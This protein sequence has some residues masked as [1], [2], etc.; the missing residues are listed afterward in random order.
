MAVFAEGRVEYQKLNETVALLS[1]T[2]LLSFGRLFG[3]QLNSL[4]KSVSA[5][6]EK[7][8]DFIP[9]VFTT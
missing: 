1:T 2:A 9:I 5:N 8:L 6:A 3:V 4:E 7:R